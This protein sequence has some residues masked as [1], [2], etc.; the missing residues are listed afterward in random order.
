M[1]LSSL[2]S[3]VSDNPQSDFIHGVVSKVERF[4]TLSLS[5]KESYL[6]KVLGV[7]ILTHPQVMS[8]RYSYSSRF[9]I[10][11]WGELKGKT[12]LDVGTGSGILA[13]FAALQ[14]AT[15]VL[16]VD[17]NNY[18]VESARESVKLNCLEKNVRV[19]QSNLF[20]EIKGSGLFFDRII[21]NAPFWNR[22]ANP[23]IPLTLALY[24]ENYSLTSQFLEEAANYL[25]PDGLILLAFSRQ[26]DI[27]LLDELIASSP[28]KILSQIEET[29][30][31][32]RIL[33][34]LG[35]R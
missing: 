15:F 14:G 2:N 30:G 25:S 33:F 6:T 7:P 11:N 3:A 19:L 9:I 4:I 16:G 21:F 17:I 29:R 1:F 20:S 18:A 35:R 31:H 5:H 23:E 22:P 27:Q 24:D 8:P 34:T 28:L 32:T 10:N 13:V 12:V 26:D